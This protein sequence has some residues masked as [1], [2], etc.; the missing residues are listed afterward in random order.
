MNFQD[1]L[2]IEN[3][4]LTDGSVV[5]VSCIYNKTL[6]PPGFECGSLQIKGPNSHCGRMLV[7]WSTYLIN[8]KNFIEVK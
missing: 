4:D 2:N 1:G 7:T 5:I 3:I 8:R 6:C